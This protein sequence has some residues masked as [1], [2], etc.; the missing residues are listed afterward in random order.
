MTFATDFDSYLSE[1]FTISD[2]KD[3]IKRLKAETTAQML[4]NIDVSVLTKIPAPKLSKM[5]KGRQGITCTD[6]RMWARVLGYTPEPFILDNFD[7][8]R[9][10]LSDHVRSVTDC[11]EDYIET[12][13]EDSRHDAIINYELP[14][15]ITAT[16]GLRASDYFFNT[17]SSDAENRSTFL[18]F[19]NRTI[20]GK[21]HKVMPVISFYLDDRCDEMAFILYLETPDLDD[22]SLLKVRNK[23]RKLIES[24]D[25]EDEQLFN[26]FYENNKQH[27]HQSIANGEILSYVSTTEVLP[28]DDMMREI[29]GTLFSA[30]CD[31][32]WD[33]YDIDIIPDYFKAAED[34]GLSPMEQFNIMTGKEGFDESVKKKALENASYH[35]EISDEHRTFTDRRGNQY[36]TV[37]PLIPFMPG[38][39]YGKAI[40]KEANAVCLCPNCAAQL[41]N[42]TD[43]D[44]TEMVIKLYRKHADK[45]K[46]VGIDIKLGD[47]LKMYQL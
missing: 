23:Y 32:V 33:L 34:S 41:M 31:L 3:V 12:D 15:S 30:Y 13:E 19:M 36:M 11:I 27:I 6:V 1:P 38:I 39:I 18:Y 26:E 29:L 46:A 47:L 21:G 22:E 5:V 24:A 4:K 2:E 25:Y 45:L 40:K 42:G 28:G 10:R 7:M 17:K 9:Y 8:R 37:V 16:L 20:L 14:L 35:C 44:R 43:E